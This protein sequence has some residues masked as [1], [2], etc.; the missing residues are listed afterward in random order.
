MSSWTA[1]LYLLI[2]QKQIITNQPECISWYLEDSISFSSEPQKVQFLPHRGL[3]R[4]DGGKRIDSPDSLH[5][6]EKPTGEEIAS[7]CQ[8]LTERPSLHRRSVPPF[9]KLL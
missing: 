9:R 1:N 5:P 7:N 6:T 8:V 4:F 2:E 3:A